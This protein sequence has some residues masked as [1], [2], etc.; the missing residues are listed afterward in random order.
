MTTISKVDSSV[1]H[2]SRFSGCKITGHELNRML[3]Y[4]F[5]V[6]G[7]CYLRNI[8]RPANKG[9]KESVRTAAYW[10]RGFTM[11]WGAL[12]MCKYLL[13]DSDLLSKKKNKVKSAKDSKYDGFT[14]TPRRAGTVFGLSLI[15]GGM[16]AA[17]SF[18]KPVKLY[19]SKYTRAFWD[20]SR[21]FLVTAGCSTVAA[22]VAS[23]LKSS[24]SST[25]RDV[26]PLK[27]DFSPP[28]TDTEKNLS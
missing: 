12:A 24:A 16:N 11:T 17:L 13:A 18:T 7:F 27:K 22:T 2:K 4:G 3:D 5:I 15:A 23:L 26:K 14:I 1:P 20:F 8:N 19:K 21:G 25:S 6:G 10:L 28:K 9:V